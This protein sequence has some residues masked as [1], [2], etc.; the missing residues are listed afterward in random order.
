[1]A[2]SI[3]HMQ[4][5]CGLRRRQ[6][7]RG[8]RRRRFR[9]GD[10]LRARRARRTSVRRQRLRSCGRVWRSSIVC[11]SRARVVPR[12]QLLCQQASG[13]ATESF[14]E[15][16]ISDR[17]AVE[18]HGVVRLSDTFVCKALADVHEL[19]TAGLTSMSRET[20]CPHSQQQRPRSH[21][22]LERRSL[23]SKEPSRYATSRRCRAPAARLG[24]RG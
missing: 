22:R 6:G 24:R 18:C 19:S 14:L 1:M 2:S 20:V 9:H 10:L 7:E 4:G 15:R 13:S 11:E 5:E 12:R 8:F 21:H 16:K 17:S 23:W 3:I